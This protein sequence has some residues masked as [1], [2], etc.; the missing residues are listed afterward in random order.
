MNEPAADVLRLPEDVAHRLL[1]RAVELDAARATQIPVG[2][3]R[4]IARE[5]GISEAALEAAAARWARSLQ[6]LG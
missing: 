5:A 1:A 2:Q 4:E 3:L 6:V